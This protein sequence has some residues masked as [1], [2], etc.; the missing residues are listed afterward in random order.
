[1]G[2][3]ALLR[4]RP[5]LTP[6]ERKQIAAGLAEAARCTRARIG[7]VIEARAREDPSTLA[8]RRLEEFL[9]EA[10]RGRAILLYVREHPPGFAVAAG[11]EVRRVTPIPFWEL[12]D[13]DLRHHFDEARYCDG[14]F[15]ALSQIALQLEHHYPPLRR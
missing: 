10:E 12:L 13:R 8:P 5:F 3:F 4:R 6:D 7:L 15:K 11:E 9:P 1:M 2:L 14:I